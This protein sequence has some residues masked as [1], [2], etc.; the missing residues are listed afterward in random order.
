MLRL[1]S[2]EDYAGARCCIRNHLLVGLVYAAQAIEK[3]LKAHILAIDPG[4]NVRS[5][6]HSLSE[7]ANAASTIDSNLDFQ[8]YRH[9]LHQL[10]GHYNSRYP[11]N[12][13]QSQVM[14]SGGLDEIDELYVYVE[15]SWRGS[16]DQLH[17]T[18]LSTMLF[19]AESRGI[20]EAD[21]PTAYWCKL[22]N[23]PLARWAS[24]SRAVWYAVRGQQPP[25]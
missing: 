4:Y 12:P 19:V 9:V 1:A 2:V 22:E 6:G 7:I 11:D 14:S 13:A 23:D 3:L 16:V 25:T 24:T 15:S 8:P 20:A 17:H 21:V 10:E 5:L 18:G